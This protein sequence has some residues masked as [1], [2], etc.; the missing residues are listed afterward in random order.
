M[1]CRNPKN[2]GLRV[3]PAH[4]PRRMSREESREPRHRSIGKTAKCIFASLEKL[5]VERLRI[6]NIHPPKVRQRNLD[7]RLLVI[8]PERHSVNV[9]MQISA[10][11]PQNASTLDRHVEP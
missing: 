9:D 11:C 4:G 8:R 2:P 10:R 3:V 5:K 7:L 6:G 1:I